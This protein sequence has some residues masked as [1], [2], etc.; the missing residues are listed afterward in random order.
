MKENTM[1][2][3]EYVGFSVPKFQAIILVN[4]EEGNATRIIIIDETNGDFDVSDIL[5]L[6]KQELDTHPELSVVKIN[7]PGNKDDFQIALLDALTNPGTET[8]KSS[9][10][11][12]STSEKS[13]YSRPPEGWMNA[14][15]IYT[16]LNKSSDWFTSALKNITINQEQTGTHLNK[17]NKPSVYYSPEV[18]KQ[19]SRLAD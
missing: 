15:E 19:G 14:H 7:Y 12:K 8:K 16:M 10:E 3:K 1:R 5:G 4:N 17:A 11:K 2:N 6:T 9:T 13:D 18:I